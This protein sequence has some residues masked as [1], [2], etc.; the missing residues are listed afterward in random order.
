MPINFNHAD[1]LLLVDVQRDFCPG[2]SLAIPEGDTIVPVLNHWIDAATAAGILVVASRDWHPPNHVSF[3]PRGGPW[4]VHCVRDTQGAAFHA[5][6]HLPPNALIVSKAF[7]EERDAY[8]AFDGTDLSLQLKNDKITRLWIGG[9]AEDVCVKATVLDALREGFEV[10]LI[11]GGM[12][13]VTEKGGKEAQQQ[14][15][16]AGARTG[17]LD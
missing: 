9:L 10:R 11:Q 13:P 5:D 16:Q 15:Q 4:P 17:S 12:R 14:M 3:A 1:A 7:D 2:G 8:S 6:L